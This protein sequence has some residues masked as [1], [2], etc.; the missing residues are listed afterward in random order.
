M[1]GWKRRKE[2]KMTRKIKPCTLKIGYPNGNI[3]EL[4]LKD[5]PI[6]IDGWMLVETV[7]GKKMAFSNTQVAMAEMIEEDRT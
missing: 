1:I 3:I 4:N 2:K 7:E 6:F 5:S